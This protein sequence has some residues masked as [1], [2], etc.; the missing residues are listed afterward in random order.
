ML[1]CVTFAIIRQ[2]QIRLRDLASNSSAGQVQLCISGYWQ[3]VCST[4]NPLQE[5]Y[6]FTA[7]DSTVA[8]YQLGF[9]KGSP[10]G[11]P[12]SGCKPDQEMF[13]VVHPS[14]QGWEE[15][16][17]NCSL[18]V[19]PAGVCTLETAVSVTCE[20]ELLRHVG[21]IQYQISFRLT[22]FNVPAPWQLL[23][24]LGSSTG[25]PSATWAR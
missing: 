5:S 3:T 7:T 20:G 2:G 10:A 8:C 16:L 12:G 24:R 23:Y 19:V 14:C 17:S 13:L 15:Q 6:E 11:T 1:V 22:L 4:T 21:C 18:Q 9:T 25:T